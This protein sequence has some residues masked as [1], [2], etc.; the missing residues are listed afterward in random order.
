MYGEC[1]EVK[2]DQVNAVKVF[3]LCS[4]FTGKE[5]KKK[6]ALVE[7]KQIIDRQLTEME[8]VNYSSIQEEVLLIDTK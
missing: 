1:V 5:E 8:Y 7:L 4:P 6:K 3:V 2:L